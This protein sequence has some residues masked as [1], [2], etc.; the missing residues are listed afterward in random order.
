MT[1]PVNRMDSLSVSAILQVYSPEEIEAEIDRLKTE[2]RNAYFSISAG[3]KSGTRAVEK[4]TAD[5]DAFAA[6]KETLEGGS[7]G[8]VTEQANWGGN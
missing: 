2:F 3:G 1:A 5:L 7:P 4:I 6:A 8:V